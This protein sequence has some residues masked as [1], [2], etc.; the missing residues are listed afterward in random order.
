LVAG[1]ITVGYVIPAHVIYSRSE[2]KMML[3]HFGTPYRAYRD[4]TG[5]FVPRLH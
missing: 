2:E 5:G 1:L 3:E 4:T